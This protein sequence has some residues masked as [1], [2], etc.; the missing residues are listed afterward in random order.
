[1]WVANGRLG[2]D[3]VVLEEHRAPDLGAKHVLVKMKAA[4]ITHIDLMM[5]Q[6]R[7]NTAICCVHSRY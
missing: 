7:L 3:H 4:S 6:V 1:M 5:A 2:L